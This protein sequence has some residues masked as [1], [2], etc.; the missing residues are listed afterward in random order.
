MRETKLLPF[1]VVVVV[2]VISMI[3]ARCFFLA[4]IRKSGCKNEIP[5]HALR[6]GSVCSDPGGWGEQAPK[7]NFF[8]GL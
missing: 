5:L 1:V 8:Q 3:E 2:V 7:E 6:L 4:T